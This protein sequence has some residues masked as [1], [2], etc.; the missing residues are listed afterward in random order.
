MITVAATFVLVL[1]RVGALLSVLPVFS[2]VG[3]P[4]WVTAFA[5]MAVSALL[6][7]T[8]PPPDLPE[9]LH[10]VAVALG[11]EVLFGMFLGL[12]VAAAFAALA[13]GAEIMSA[14]M[15]LSFAT[16]FDPL[17]RSTESVLGSFA[18]WMAALVFVATGLDGR[19]LEIVAASFERVPPG[20][21]ALPGGSAEL[22]MNAAGQCLVL[23]VQLS[24]PVVAMVFLVH[25][26]VAILS[27]LAPRMHAFFSVGTTAT[28][29]VGVT[30]L[31]VSLPW[32]MS[33]HAG[34]L[35]DAVAMVAR[36]VA[37]GR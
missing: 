31:M 3:V 22:A 1:G 2:M 24:G 35:V 21:A 28:G 23:G 11:G 8:L 10:R 27:K 30:M 32:V 4:R 9:E 7:T 13:L 29:A 14:Q 25:L 33:A 20:A 26:F 15:G 19:C 5:A 16:L 18:S 12:G 6:T 36:A 17:T 37:A 34:A